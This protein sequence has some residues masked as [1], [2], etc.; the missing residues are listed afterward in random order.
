MDLSLPTQ[1]VDA[2]LYHLARYS[3]YTLELSHTSILRPLRI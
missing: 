1:G 3:P 2:H